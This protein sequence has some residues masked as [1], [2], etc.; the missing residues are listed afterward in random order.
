MTIMRV[1][2]SGTKLSDSDKSLMVDRLIGAFASIEVGHD[3][4]EIRNG[5]VVQFEELAAVDSWMGTRPMAASNPSGRSA[6][7]ACQVMAGPWNSEMKQELIARLD[8]IVR[9]VA[10]IPRNGSG[11][12]VWITFVEVPEGAWGVGGRAVSIGR[13]APVFEADRQERI[14]AYLAGQATG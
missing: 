6:V 5:F 1:S 12:D 13:L 2:L 8:E 9:D 10:D 7:I 11:S 3:S 14:A 4:S